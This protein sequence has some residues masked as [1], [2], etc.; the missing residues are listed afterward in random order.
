V[1]EQQI[2]L[3]SYDEDFGIYLERQAI[4][5]M[6]RTYTLCVGLTRSGKTVCKYLKR[7]TCGQC[8]NLRKEWGKCKISGSLPHIDHSRLSSNSQRI[9][10]NT[11]L[12]LLT[13]SLKGSK[14]KT[15]QN[16]QG[17]RKKAEIL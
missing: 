3:N 8:W 11:K 13:L 2:K 4:R 16:K 7:E 10:A 12:F 15:K 1:I 6:S 5:L 9:V 17:F 14:N